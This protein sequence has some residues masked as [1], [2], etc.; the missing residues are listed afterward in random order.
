MNTLTYVEATS[1][2]A[3]CLTKYIVETL[4]QHNLDSMSIVS[5]GYDGAS[6]MSSGVQQREIPHKPILLCSHIELKSW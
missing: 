3:E 4:Q 2:T 5:Q 1:L 6:V